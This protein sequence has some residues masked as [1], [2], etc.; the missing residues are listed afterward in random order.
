[1][2]G[3]LYFIDCVADFNKFVIGKDIAFGVIAGVTCQDAIFW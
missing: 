2:S 3:L 1:M